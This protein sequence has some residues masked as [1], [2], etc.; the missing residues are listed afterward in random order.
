[1]ASPE[2]FI[3][4]LFWGLMETGRDWLVL[5]RHCCVQSL[6][7][8]ETWSRDA[9]KRWANPPFSPTLRTDAP[10]LG[11]S[12]PS[13]ALPHERPSPRLG[14]ERSQRLLSTPQLRR[15]SGRGG[16]GNGRCRREE[17]N[18]TTRQNKTKQY[19]TDL[20][21]ASCSP[22][23]FD[24]DVVSAHWLVASQGECPPPR[25]WTHEGLKACHLQAQCMGN[26]TLHHHHHHHLCHSVITGIFS[27]DQF[28]LNKATVNSNIYLLNLSSYLSL[29]H[30]MSTIDRLPW[31]SIS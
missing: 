1:M 14:V 23:R 13:K 5:L 10:S 3:S 22:R 16:V 8:Q 21:H 24:Y 17:I 28:K 4:S 29:W 11:W 9:F 6:S 31:V 30:H 7:C 15:S 12:G 25:N 27:S 19:T 20:L 26:T 2:W 18:S